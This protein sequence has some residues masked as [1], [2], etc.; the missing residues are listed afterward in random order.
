MRP[1]QSLTEEERKEIYEFA[2]KRS[3]EILRNAEVNEEAAEEI[4]K[5]AREFASAF[6]KL[7]EGME[8][9]NPEDYHKVIRGS[10]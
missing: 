8:G 7:T 9:L 5:Q 2:M 3:E 6:K 4:S 10:K 1:I